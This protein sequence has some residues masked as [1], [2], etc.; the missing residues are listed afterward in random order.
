MLDALAAIHLEIFLDLAGIAGVFVDRN[1]DLA[2]GTGQRPREQA[3]RAALDVEKADLAE[4]EQSFV[5]A[6]PDIH[7]AAMDV[8][9]EVIDIMQ[10]GAFR[11]RVFGAEPLELGVIGRPPGAVAID[12]IEQAA[13]DPLD[14]GN[15]ERLLRGR[16]I[17]GLRAERQRALKGRFRIDDAKRHRRRARPVRG[18]KVKAVGAGLLVDEVVDVALAIDRDLLAAVARDRRIAHQLEQPVQRRRVGVRIFDEF[19]AVGAHRV[20]GAD[21]RCRR[22]VR[23]WTHG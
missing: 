21:D 7:A 20:V 16:N 3:G 11:P 9:G 22:V 1:A 8:V 6:G 2:V 5:E 10:P 18:D 14:G 4:I 23:K 13:A 12:E 19:E 17:G 15:V